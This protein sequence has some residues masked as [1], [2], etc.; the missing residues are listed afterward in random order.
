MRDFEPNRSRAFDCKDF[1]DATIE[2]T[3]LTTLE[4]S[5]AYRINVPNAATIRARAPL[6]F[7]TTPWQLYPDDHTKPFGQCA[8][9]NATTIEQNQPNLGAEK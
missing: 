4:P 2:A 3:I 8:P 1:G 5:A 9:T 7:P 6:D